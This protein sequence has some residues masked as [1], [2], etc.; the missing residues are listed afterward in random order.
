MSESMPGRQPIQ[1]AE[2]IQPRCG[3]VFGVSPCTAS[4]SGDAKCYNTRASCADPANY[5][6]DPEGAMGTPSLYLSNKELMEPNDVQRNANLF[7]AFDLTFAAMPQG[8]IWELGGGTLGA[9]LGVTSGR[10]VFRAGDA[11]VTD[12]PDVAKVSVAVEPWAGRSLTLYLEIS[13]TS[14]RVTLWA[15]DRIEKTVT[16]IGT[17]T[18]TSLALW[19]NADAGG[20]G[21]KGGSDVPEGESEDDWNG[22]ISQGR[23]WSNKLALDMTS[24]FRLNLFFGSDS[25]AFVNVDGAPYLMPTV[26]SVRTSPASINL[27]GSN[28]DAGGLGT[29]ATCRLN[30]DDLIGSDN[31]VDPYVAERSWDASDGTRGTY[32]ARWG[33]RNPFR[34]NMV[35]RLHEGY[36]GQPLTD[37]R[38]RLYLV[39]DLKINPGGTAAFECKD[40]L[41]RLANRKAQAP[42]ASSGRLSTPLGATDTVI[43]VVDGFAEDY[44]SAGTIRIGK[45]LLTYSSRSG[46]DGSLVFT[47]VARGQDSTAPQSHKVGEV[48]QTCIRFDREDVVDVLELL[49]TKYGG[50]DAAFLDLEGWREEYRE[51]RSFYKLSTV[52]SDPESVQKLVSEILDQTQTVLWP[53]ERTA[54][55]RFR[56]VRASATPPPLLTQDA[57]IVAD[58]FRVREKPRERLSQVWVYWGRNDVLSRVDDATVYNTFIRADLASET[59]ERYGSPSIYKM[60]ARWLPTRALALSTASRVLT[61]RVDTPKEVVFDLDAKDR[62]YWTGDVVRI[63]HNDIR[64]VYGSPVVKTWF[65]LSAHETISGHRVSYV[66]EDITNLPAIAYVMPSGSPD[67]PGA[68][69][70]PEKYAYIGEAGTNE[71]PDGTD[72]ARIS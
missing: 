62:K 27:G 22:R 33:A 18:A 4:G 38:K 36:V 63:L 47:G 2:L 45:E 54:K 9:Y 44:P 21:T 12:G 11:T 19:A 50:M 42:A 66:A 13:R 34:Q 70:L 69:N 16:Q 31:L 17:A 37:F 20:C 3:N 60:F 51:F 52:L 5:R 58:S 30:V 15:W 57:N 40:V 28:P 29:R 26:T 61:R 65:I 25:T 7:A 6:Q 24:D 35:M 10:L 39:E 1:I 23:L 68:G 64:D 71:L 59:D 72:G 53:D 43:N 46:S 14:N 32:W 48:V 41:T 8:V 67:Y 55:V 56:A 49:I